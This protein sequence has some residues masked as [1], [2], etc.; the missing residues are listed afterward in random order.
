[1]NLIKTCPSCGKKI[2][3]PLD[4]GKIKVKCT[5]GY[6]FVA[7]PDDTS[8]YKNGEFDLKGKKSLRPGLFSW[9]RR[10]FN[11]SS[12]EIFTWNHIINSLLNAKYK[13]QNFRLLPASEQK[14]ILSIVFAVTI[15]IIAVIL[16]ITSIF[17]KPDE[18]VV[19]I[20]LLSIF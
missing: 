3:F 8:I 2:R 4:K 10:L 14:K 7:D 13:I 9:V 19:V 15:I 18:N 1:M 17:N 12:T 6:S 16:I 5:C 11:S 20:S